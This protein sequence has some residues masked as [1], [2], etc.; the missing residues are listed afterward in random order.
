MKTKNSINFIYLFSLLIYSI[1]SFLVL[2]AFSQA[3]VNDDNKIYTGVEHYP[4]F[5]GGEADFAKFLTNTINYPLEAA[6]QNVKGRVY[7]QFVVE[8]D[9]SLTD[10]K[11]LREP[12][13]GHSLG[14]EAIRVLK[15]SPKWTPGTQDGKN[16]R[17]QY[18][19]PINFNIAAPPVQPTSNTVTA[20][21]TDV[22]T[23]N[24]FSD[25]SKRGIYYLSTSHPPFFNGGTQALNDFLKNNI[26]YPEGIETKHN[27]RVIT[28]FIVETD[29]SLSNISTLFKD[30]STFA[31]EA[32]RVLKLSPKWSPGIFENKSEKTPQ[33]TLV[34]LPID[35]A[36]KNTPLP[37]IKTTQDSIDNHLIF[38][39]DDQ[40]PAFP[41]GEAGF[42]KFLVDHV[43]YPALA[44]ERDV[45]GRVFVQFV[46]EKDGTLTHLHILR[47]PGSG[48]GDETV[49]VLTLSPPW[50][51]AVKS[52][53]HVRVSYTVPMNYNTAP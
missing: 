4:I 38:T 10:I 47:D 29:G 15:L 25:T 51:P 34:V 20:N 26:K 53:Q 14:E 49:R 19:V 13:N 33:R 16:V 40:Q 52:G 17:V 39:T 6:M 21:G 18:V 28:E 3:T 48:L 23:F 1:L 27:A 8:K 2:P 45:T 22:K 43:R 7:A 37:E 36:S 9:G 31:K 46:V 35:F 44:K 50:I 11:I 32:L 5:P 41:G 30:D 42:G 12:N 24:S